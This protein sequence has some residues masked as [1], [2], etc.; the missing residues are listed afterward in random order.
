LKN[1]PGRAI[2]P[3]FRR[4][5]GR[6]NAGKGSREERKGEKEGPKWDPLASKPGYGPSKHLNIIRPSHFSKLANF[7]R[8]YCLYSDQARML[9]V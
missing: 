8:R 7:S 5:E 4:G 2:G 9:I 6:Q 3:R 1:V